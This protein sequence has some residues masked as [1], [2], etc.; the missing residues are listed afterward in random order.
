ML[1]NDGVIQWGARYFLV[2]IP[3]TV[4]A[5]AL[6]E[7][8]WNII[9][10]RKIPLWLTCFILL[11]TAYCFYHNTYKG[12]RE[13]RWRYDHRLN[14]SY[15]LLQKNPGSV[16]VMSHQSMSYDFAYLFDKNYFFAAPGDD[17]LRRL[18]P[19]L[20]KYG[21]HQYIYMFD[22]RVPTLPKMLEDSTT[23]YLWDDVT[24]KPYI[25]DEFQCKVYTIK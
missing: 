18:L 19:L 4:V 25:K 3:V 17:S 10:T 12:Y 23:S 22:P 9:E 24:K 14:A 5:L 13:I 1:P 2:I 6:A 15:D 7:K 20:K 16:V 21:V 11:G 8:Q